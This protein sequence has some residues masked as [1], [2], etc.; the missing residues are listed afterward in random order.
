MFQAVDYPRLTQISRPSASGAA[1]A[2]WLVD[3]VP[4]L[5][6]EEAIEA[7]DVPPVLA[8]E[9]VELLRHVPD[10]WTA[11]EDLRALIT[12]GIPHADGHA[13]IRLLRVLFDKGFLEVDEARIRRGSMPAA[14]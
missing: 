6:L 8:A 2:F 9:E 13:R 1:E 14:G 4:V 12:S 5:N 10:E 11:P 3:G 7:L